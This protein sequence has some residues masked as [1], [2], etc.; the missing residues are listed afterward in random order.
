MWYTIAIIIMVLVIL[1]A[2]QTNKEIEN[3][4]QRADIMSSAGQLAKTL[5]DLNKEKAHI[6]S[7]K[8]IGLITKKSFDSL[9]G[10]MFR[11]IKGFENIYIFS[12][13]RKNQQIVFV[14]GAHKDIIPIEQINGVEILIDNVSVWLWDKNKEKYEGYINLDNAVKE[15]T[16]SFTTERT[17]ASIQVKISLTTV[18]NPY[19]IFDCFDCKTISLNGLPMAVKNNSLT[20]IYLQCLFDSEQIA[21]AVCCI[22]KESTDEQN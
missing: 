2:F 19:V 20:Y 15:Y 16:N 9:N 14:K 13:D 7:L 18:A 5:N 21:D 22:L 6:D 1:K 10:E 4:I 12:E 3:T 11:I 17:I 8:S